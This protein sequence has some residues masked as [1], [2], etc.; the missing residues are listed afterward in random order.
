MVMQSFEKS[1][2]STD[3]VDGKPLQHDVYTKGDGPVILLIQELP[4]IGT[5]TLRLADKLVNAGFRVVMPHIFGPL[6]KLSF[7]GNTAR[8]FCMRREFSLFA[9]KRSSPVVNWLRALCAELKQQYD[10]PGIG[11]IGMCLS[12]NF[13]ISLMADDAVLAGVS[14]QPSLPLGSQ[15]A[16]HMSDKDVAQIRESLDEKGAMLAFRFAGDKLCTQTKFTALDAAFNDDKER[17]KLTNIVGNAHSLLTVHF[18]DEV[19]SPTDEALQEVIAY[20]G[21]KLSDNTAEPIARATDANS[22]S[23][24]A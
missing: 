23:S 4:G 12:G 13:A 19:G 17:I 5:E 22:P 15:S 14:S 21:D 24:S 10:V 2:F 1:V 9:K 16:L 3:A 11:V 7:I 18:I 8:L 20:F 6:G